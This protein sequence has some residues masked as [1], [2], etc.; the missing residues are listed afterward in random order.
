MAIFHSYVSLPEGSSCTEEHLKLIKA[1]F[2]NANSEGN[3]GTELLLWSV[4]E[5]MQGEL[6]LQGWAIL[7]Q[8]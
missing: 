7:T 3:Q 1:L 6:V 5:I 2:A 4:R 8:D